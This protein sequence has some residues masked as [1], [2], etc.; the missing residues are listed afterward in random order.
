[1]QPDVCTTSQ[2]VLVASMLQTP[3]ATALLNMKALRQMTRLGLHV[4]H[5]I[6]KTLPHGIADESKSVTTLRIYEIQAYHLVADITS[7]C[8]HCGNFPTSG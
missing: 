6:R 7:F 5:A 4:H 3:P 2:I 1:M 8:A